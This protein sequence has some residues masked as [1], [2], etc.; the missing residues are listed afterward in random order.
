M[1]LS[2]E[3]VA[4]K[5]GQSGSGEV[6]YSLLWLFRLITCQGTSLHLN[7]KHVPYVQVNTNDLIKHKIY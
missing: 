1:A 6:E 7:H 5:T 3:W 2:T 4:L